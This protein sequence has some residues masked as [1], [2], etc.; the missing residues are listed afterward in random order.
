LVSDEKRFRV[1]RAIESDESLTTDFE[2]W[3]F[4]KIEEFDNLS[5]E[6]GVKSST[7]VSG[8]G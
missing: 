4:E 5:T 7:G 8:I 6:G 3:I 1:C 2:F